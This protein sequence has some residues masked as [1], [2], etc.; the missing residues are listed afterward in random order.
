MKTF[1][2]ASFFVLAISLLTASVSAQQASNPPF[3]FPRHVS[4]PGEKTDEERRREMARPAR[5]DRVIRKGFLAPSE[6]DRT[7]YAAFLKQSDT[8]L[9]R[10]LP[11]ERANE[12]RLKIRGGGAYYSFHYLSHEYGY[13]SDIQLKNHDMLSVGFAGADYGMLTK[14]GDVPL[15]E[16]TAKHPRAHLLVNYE[17]L[18]SDPEARC[19]HRRFVV[20]VVID[21]RLYK[22]MLP[23]E[24]GATYLLRSFN[25]GESDVLV[26]FRVAKRDDDGSVIIAWK[27]LKEFA[28]R[29]LENVNVKGKCNDPIVIIKSH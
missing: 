22:S 13:G 6:Q 26:G 16:I 7:D 25:Y 28:P 29:K 17:P 8:G 23:V 4:V 21:G 3:D 24:V 10:L 15:D 12:R 20:G 9:I 1:F 5:E 19:E 18:H 14:L 11:Y 2:A 27:L